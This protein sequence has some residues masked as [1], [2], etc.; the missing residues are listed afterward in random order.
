MGQCAVLRG[1]AWSV[2]GKTRK[3]SRPS[4]HDPHDRLGNDDG[5][6]SSPSLTG[7]LTDG[8]GAPGHLHSWIN[9]FSFLAPPSRWLH[10]NFLSPLGLLFLSPGQQMP[11]LCSYKTT[12]TTKKT[13][14]NRLLSYFFSNPQIIQDRIEKGYV[15]HCLTVLV[16]MLPESRITRGSWG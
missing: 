16:Q 13:I 15:T 12:T 2:K 6:F 7:S 8:M 3:A 1:D 9:R 5:S 11:V 10:L 14:Y 4:S